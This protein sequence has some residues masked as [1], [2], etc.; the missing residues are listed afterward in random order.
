MIIELQVDEVVVTGRI[1]WRSVSDLSV[2]ILEPYKGYSH[3]LHLMNL[4]RHETTLR[5]GYLGPLGVERAEVMLRGLYEVAK[6]LNEYPLT[7]LEIFEPYHRIAVALQMTEHD[8]H[9]RRAALRRSLKNGRFDNAKHSLLQLE[10]RREKV[11]SNGNASSVMDAFV[12]KYLPHARCITV[13]DQ[14]WHQLTTMLVLRGQSK[15]I[16][17]TDD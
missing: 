12:V 2:E 3:N 17:D 6:L 10:L 11:R 8:F 16:G 13:R 14:V 5:E 9:Q 15:G 1:T 4:A 7:L